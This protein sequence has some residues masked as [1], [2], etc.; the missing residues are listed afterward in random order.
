MNSAFKIF[1]GA[2]KIHPLGFSGSGS[3]PWG[4][5]KIPGIKLIYEGH[6]SRVDRKNSKLESFYSSWKEASEV[7]KNRPKLERAN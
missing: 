7:G 6:I 2:W 3:S 4:K 1:Y 5:L